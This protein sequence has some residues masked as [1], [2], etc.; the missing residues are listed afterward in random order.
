[1]ESEFTRWV[2]YCKEAGVSAVFEARTPGS[3]TLTERV[4]EV[5]VKMDKKGKLLY[6]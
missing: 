1:M 4:Y 3:S 2:E 6:M 5:L